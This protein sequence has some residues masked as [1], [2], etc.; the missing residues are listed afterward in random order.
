[1]ITTELKVDVQKYEK[2]K[3]MYKVFSVND[4]GVIQGINAKTDKIEVLSER[5][6]RDYFNFLTN[7][8]HVYKHASNYYNG[9]YEYAEKAERYSDW[10]EQLRFAKKV[11]EDILK[12]S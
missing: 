12:V 6:I 4:K 8:V 3:P 10:L 7:A 9:D 1:M 2:S 11:S 5:V